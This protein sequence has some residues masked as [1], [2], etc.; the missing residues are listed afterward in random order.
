MRTHDAAESALGTNNQ[1]ASQICKDAAKLRDNQRSQA[2]EAK[3]NGKLE[4]RNYYAYIAYEVR[5]PSL[6]FRIS[7]LMDVYYP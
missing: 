2:R 6:Y 5:L 7:L 1:A 4:R 3:R